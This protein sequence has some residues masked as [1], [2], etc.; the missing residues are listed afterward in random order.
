MDDQR[1][2]LAFV[3]HTGKIKKNSRVGIRFSSKEPV[4]VFLR[5]LTTLAELQNIILQKFGV[6]NSKRVSKLFYR[7]PVVVVSEHVQDFPE[8]R[9][10]ELYAKL[11][12]IVASSDGSNQHPQSIHIGG[13]S[14]LPPPAAPAGPVIPPLVASPSFAADLHRDDDDEYDL[15]DNRA[16]GE[17]VTAVAS[18]PRTP[19]MG[20]QISEPEGVEEALREDEEEEEPELIADDSNEDDQS[21][22]PP[23]CAP[24]SSGSHQ[25]P[26]H[27][28]SL[29]LE[30]IAPTR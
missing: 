26:E 17:L 1:S 28:S 10:T 7:A 13:S 14:S 2:F 11:V 24:C 5:T 30:S 15:D 29:D 6:A 19:R 4:S 8:V 16:F 27:F 18:N 3:H 25:Y 20:I 12:D 9:T 23:R 22:P 21:I